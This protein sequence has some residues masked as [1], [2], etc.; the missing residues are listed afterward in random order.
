MEE[1]AFA[2]RLL[3]T[4]LTLEHESTRTMSN[5]SSLWSYNYFSII[6]IYRK[7]RSEPL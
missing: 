7:S 6:C 2:A 5:G 3:G 4:I 1:N